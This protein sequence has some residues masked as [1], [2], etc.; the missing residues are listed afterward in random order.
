MDFQNQTE[1]DKKLL[2]VTAIQ[3]Y[4]DSR[5][6]SEADALHTQPL[7][8][9]LKSFYVSKTFTALKKLDSEMWAESAEFIADEFE[10][11]QER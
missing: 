7:D 2:V 1:M 3:G 11:E 5:N 8:M 10:K 6:I 9:A 4:A